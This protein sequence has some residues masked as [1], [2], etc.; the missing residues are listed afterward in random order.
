MLEK[1][2]GELAA[3]QKQVTGEGLGAIR[4]DMDPKNFG[5]INSV[6]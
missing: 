1:L 2:F 6:P 4:V 5:A 3:V